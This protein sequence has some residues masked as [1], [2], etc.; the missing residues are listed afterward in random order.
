MASAMQ[1]L[2]DGFVFADFGSRSTCV[3]Q[4]GRTVD[5]EDGIGEWPPSP[6]F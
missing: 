5:I 6:F 1:V 4:P 2:Y 3:T